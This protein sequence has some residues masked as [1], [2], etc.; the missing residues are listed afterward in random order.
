MTNEVVYLDESRVKLYGMNRYVTVRCPSC[1]SV[2][3]LKA[4]AIRSEVFFCPVCEDGEIEYHPEPPKVF[5]K[6]TRLSLKRQKLVP[7]YITAH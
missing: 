7:V 6:D 4:D 3:Q 1:R 2:S 5:H